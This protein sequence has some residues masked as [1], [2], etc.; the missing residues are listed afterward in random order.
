MFW[1]D[2]IA[3]EIKRNVVPRAGVGKPLL[4][5][6]EKTASGKHKRDG[7]SISIIPGREGMLFSSRMGRM[8]SVRSSHSMLLPTKLLSTTR[9]PVVVPVIHALASA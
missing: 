4:I 6:D 9:T 7:K 5:R 8:I 2:R 3:D 1:A